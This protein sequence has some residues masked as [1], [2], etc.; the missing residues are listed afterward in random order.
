VVLYFS[1]FSAGSYARRIRANLGFSQTMEGSFKE[2]RQVVNLKELAPTLNILVSDLTSHYKY[3]LD[4]N[5]HGF[6]RGYLEKKAIEFA[7]AQ[8]WASLG[9]VMALLIFD[10]V[11]FPNL[12]GFVDDA[13]INASWV[14]KV[15]KKKKMSLLFVRMSIKSLMYDTRG[16][17]DLLLYSWFTS[18]VFKD[19]FTIKAMKMMALIESYVLWNAKKLGRE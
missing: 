11:L 8:E 4:G 10:I 6:Q 12:K 15:K 1:K 2:I 3:R 13:T 18:H 14:T 7:N 9:D 17:E 16:K 19:I 5:V